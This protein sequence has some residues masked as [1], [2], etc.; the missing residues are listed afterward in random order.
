VSGR[1]V[2]V[3][4]SVSMS[5]R[6][7]AVVVGSVYSLSDPLLHLGFLWFSRK[8]SACCLEVVADSVFGVTSFA[9]AVPFWRL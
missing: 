3:S 2:G 8:A 6:S 7:A 4:C 1:L 5:P 9:A